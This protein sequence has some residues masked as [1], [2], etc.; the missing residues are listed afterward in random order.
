MLQTTTYKF[1]DNIPGKDWFIEF[2]KRHR[3]SIKMPQS[4]EI[5]R[6]K[7]CDPFLIYDYF[8][9]LKQTLQELD[10]TNKP[11]FVWN[12]DETSFCMDPSKSKI[13][14]KIGV[15]ATRTTSAPGREN[16]TVLLACSAVGE[17]AP[18]LIVFRGKHYLG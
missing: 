1:K 2:K 8:K 9:I 6:K 14:G 18:P 10:L 16:I 13:V 15:P 5:A 7:A 4:F 11:Q 17:K 3:F 12:L